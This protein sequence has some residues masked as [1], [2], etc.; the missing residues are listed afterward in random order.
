MANKAAKKLKEIQGQQKILNKY[1]EKVKCECP[2]TKKGD[3]SFLPKKNREAGKLDYICKEC[4]KEIH[5]DKISEEDL[6]RSCT[7]IDNAIDTIKIVLNTD[8]DEDKK[9][10]EEFA[11]LQFDVRNKVVKAYGAAIS[12]SGQR[13]SNNNNRSND[14]GS[15]NKPVINGR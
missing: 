2:H 1:A 13:K 8:K 3:V 9:L 4:E 5:L 15:W 11:Q 12:Q 10:L 7:I 14:G 6:R